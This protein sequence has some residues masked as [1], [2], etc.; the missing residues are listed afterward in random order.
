MSCH[1]I[2]QIENQQRKEPAE[3]FRVGDTVRVH[4]KIVEG[5][6]ERIQAYEGLVLCFKNSGVR[7][8]FTVRKNSYGVGVE[9]IFPLHSPRIERVDVVRAGKVRRAKLYYIREKIGKAARI[10]AR[11]VK[12]PSP[13]A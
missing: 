12:K 13:S 3:T 1:L 2:Q 5:K 4:F 8:T 6:T 11:I 7:R 10:K 9:R